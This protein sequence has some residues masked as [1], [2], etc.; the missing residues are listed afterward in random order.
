M[1]EDVQK[2]EGGEKKDALDRE[3]RNFLGQKL[4]MLKQDN[5]KI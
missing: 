5:C 3:V 2:E 4:V 1:C